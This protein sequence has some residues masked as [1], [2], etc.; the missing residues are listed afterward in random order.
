M[1]Y[2]VCNCTYQSPAAQAA[3]MQKIIQASASLMDW[4]EFIILK[5]LLT[6]NYT[7]LVFLFLYLL[8]MSYLKKKK[9]NCINQ[10]GLFQFL[11]ST[12]KGW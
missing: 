8:F 6:L 1:H 7:A 2:R 11:Y 5:F 12:V 10:T 4:K 9:K 3:L